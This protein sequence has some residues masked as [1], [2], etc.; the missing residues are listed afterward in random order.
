MLERHELSNDGVPLPQW[1]VRDVHGELRLW[2]R[3][4]ARLLAWQP[5]LPRGVRRRRRHLPHRNGTTQ[6]L[7]PEHGRLRRLSRHHRLPHHRADMRP[8]DE[9]VRAMSNGQQLQRIDTP[10][11]Y[12][13]AGVRRLCIEFR[14]HERSD[15]RL[16]DDDH[17][18]RPR[19]AADHDPSMPAR[20]HEQQSVY[21]C[22]YDCLRFEWQLRAVRR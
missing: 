6:S 9:A 20:L 19:H 22:G 4:D 5:Q 16:Q 7:R 8:D 1:G 10:L 21:R 14:L 11:R 13:H 3:L 18:H 2:Q 15:A 12:D 17:V